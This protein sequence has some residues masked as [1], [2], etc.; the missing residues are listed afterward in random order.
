MRLSNSELCWDFWQ[1]VSRFGFTVTRSGASQFRHKHNANDAVASVPQRQSDISTPILTK[2]MERLRLAPFCF[3]GHPNPGR[4]S[5]EGP[6]IICGSSRKSEQTIEPSSSSADSRDHSPS[7]Q[8]CRLTW[9][10]QSAIPLNFGDSIP[11]L[12]NSVAKD[13]CGSPSR[14]RRF[15]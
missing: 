10:L 1:K 14:K 12:L 4:N 3:Q 6:G 11:V 9:S 5:S 7:L 2:G 13:L 15:L 8:L